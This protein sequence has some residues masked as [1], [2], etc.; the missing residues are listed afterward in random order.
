MSGKVGVSGANQIADRIEGLAARDRQFRDALPLAAVNEAKLRPG[1]GLAQVVAVCLEA[2]AERPALARRATSLVTD[3]VTGRASLQLDTAFETITYL[4]LWSRARALA[5][6]WYH[7]ESSPLRANDLICVMAF[8]GVDFTTVDLAAIHNGA[9]VVPLQ[10]NAPHQ[11]LRDIVKEVQPRWLATSL[12][13]LETAVDLVLDGHRPSGLLL[14]DFHPEVDDERARCEH[15]RKRLAASGIPDLILTLH[16]ALD[17]GSQLKPAPLYAEEGTETR[18]C[19]IYYTSG[20]TGSPKGAMYPESMVKASWCAV[21]PLPLLYMHYMP[22]NH[23]FGRSGVFSTLGSGGTCHFTATADLSSLFDDI[24]LARPTS[25][26]IVPRICEMVYQQYYVA[27]ERRRSEMADIDVLKHQLMMDVRNRVLGGRLLSGNFGSAPLAPDLRQ[28]MED[29]LGFKLDDHYGATEIAGA[30]RNT[31]VMR[32][33]VVEY[34]LDD[35]PE[36]G[37]FK[38]DRPYPRGELLIKT[39]S[40]MLGYFRRPEVTASV[41]DKDGFYKTGDI[42]AEVGEDQLVYVDRRNNVLKLAQGEFVAISRLEALY[43][44]GHPLIRQVYLYG[45]SERSYLLGVFVPN[46]GTLVEK[47]I[48]GDDRAIKSAL[49]EAIKDVARAEQLNAYEVPRDF[50]VE[51]EPFS[52]ENGLLAGIGKYQRPKFK[53]RYGI[54]LENLYSEI[55][56]SQANELESLRRESRDAPVAEVVARIAGATLGVGVTDLPVDA[57]FAELGGDSLSALSC[58][59]HLEEIYGIEVP[60]GVINNPSGGLLHV[61]RYIER[62]R[63]AGHQ[64]PTFASIHGRGATKICASDLTID[65]FVDAETLANA[66]DLSP[67]RA[68]VRTVLV[69]G[70]NGF[71]GRFLCLEWLQR[72]AAVGGKVI[73]IM[74][75]R[76]ASAASDRIAQAF[77]TGDANL[78]KQFEALAAQHLEVLAGDLGEHNLGLSSAAWQRLADEVDLIVHPA[79]LVNHVLPYSQL[80]GPNVLGTA[81]LIRL[82]LTSRIK[83]ISFVSTVAA[84]AVPDGGLVDED[85][86]VRVATPVRPLDGDR[87]ADGYANSK[88]AGEALLRDAHERFGLPVAVFRSGMILAHSQFTGQV[89]VPDM[90]TRWLLSIVITGVAPRSF[91]SDG[92]ANPHYDGLP[93]DFTAKSI[94]MLGANALTGYRT[95]HV[96]NPHDDGIS[97]DT[98]VDWAVVDGCKIRRIDEYADW[99]ARFETALR[100]LPEKARQ[101]SSLPLIHQFGVPWSRVAGNSVPSARFEDDVRK[102]MVG[103]DGRIPHISARFIGKYLADMRHLGLMN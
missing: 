8:A 49:R 71:L 66:S 10:T 36:L 63:Q 90:F 34:K 86:D 81:E 9:V 51:R 52:V 64:R 2:Y 31:H 96:V 14:F 11:Q 24:G 55:A 74:R 4:Q 45:T 44:N 29:C 57:T 95:W 39:N 50:I 100:A 17:G 68:P 54:R 13:C 85:A 59:L 33:P 53:E 73:C 61:S 41:F 1:L 35:V 92:S 25:M 47:G 12:E 70:A 60:V 28:F 101:Q 46:E 78:R 6:T 76:D 58:S 20:S 16:E 56:A 62:A 15:A 18:M 65:R 88:W 98:F 94:A 97:M 69:T 40:I 32:P 82:A 84:A 26:G 75:G 67:A 19:T 42:M 43:T 27:L 30:V 48:A 79:A 102:Y 93:V 80:F 3:P 21:T 5:N 89:N 87:Y 77:D 83:P 99:L 91:Y 72:V 38:T 103:G 7:S 37:Y 22:M 23:S